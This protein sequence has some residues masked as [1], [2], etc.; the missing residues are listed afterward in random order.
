MGLRV[1]STVPCWMAYEPTSLPAARVSAPSSTSSPTSPVETGTRAGSASPYV[2]CA[3]SA[4][5]VMGFCVIVSSPTPAA[6]V[7]AKFPLVV[8]GTLRA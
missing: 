5:T 3:S 7:T 6:A 2:F 4:E 1:E 8:S